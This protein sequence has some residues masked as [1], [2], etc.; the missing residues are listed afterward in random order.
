MNSSYF[1]GS[2]LFALLAL[3]TA[4]VAAQQATGSFERTLSIN[5]P[6][7][8]DVRTGS[9]AITVRNGTSGE[10]QVTGRIAVYRKFGRSTETAEELVRS[11]AAD[12]PIELSGSLLR[13]GHFDQNEFRNT[14]I[15]YEIRVPA[16][17]E[18]SSRTGSGAIR[19]E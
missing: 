3:V 4:N 19:I 17:S 14:S 10:I 12:P 2:I 15:S 18:V 1:R 6:V 8:L 5:E 11:I 13:I 16:N 7:R 9:G